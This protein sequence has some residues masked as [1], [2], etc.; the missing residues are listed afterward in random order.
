[1]TIKNQDN[2]FSVHTII[3]DGFFGLG[4]TISWGEGFI[5]VEVDGYAEDLIHLSVSEGQLEATIVDTN[6]QM[7][8]D[9]KFEKVRKE[10][11]NEST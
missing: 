5:K 3:S 6:D 2:I 10:R 7:P 1:M 4:A 11:A 8:L 9:I